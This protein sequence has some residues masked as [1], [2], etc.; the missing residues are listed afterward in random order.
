M[1]EIPFFRERVFIAVGGVAILA[2]MALLDYLQHP[3]NPTRLKE[4]AFLVYAM[5]VAVAY[6]ILHDHVTATISR[7]YFLRWKGLAD[8][9]RLSA[10][11]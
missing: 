2:A 8:D 7:E 11:P 10:G 1:D 9:P 6:G 4:Y 5:L 3:K